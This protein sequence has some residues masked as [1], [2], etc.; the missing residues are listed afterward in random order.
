MGIKETFLL[1][2]ATLTWLC[3]LFTLKGA[4]D[5]STADSKNHSFFQFLFNYLSNPPKEC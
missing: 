3:L 4:Y 2:M 1:A 5:L